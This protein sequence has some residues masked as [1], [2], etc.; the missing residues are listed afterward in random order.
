MKKMLVILASLLAMI[1]IPQTGYAYNINRWSRLLDLSPVQ[2]AKIK[3]IVYQARR[4]RIRVR[5]NLQLARLDLRQLLEQHK[6]NKSTV[7]A[8]IDKL[9]KFELLIKKS[10]ILMM[11][12]I[13]AVLTPKQAAKANKFYRRNRWRRRNNRRRFRSWKRRRRMYR[14]N[15]RRMHRRNRRRM[16]RRNRRFNRRNNHRFDGPPPT[17]MP[18]MPKK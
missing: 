9:G 14:R 5:A 15:R 17:D 12:K 6:P 13:K 10:R 2:Q 8:S 4:E 7:I 11:L 16:H 3:T 18:K 1:L